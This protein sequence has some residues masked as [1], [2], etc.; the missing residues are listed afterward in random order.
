MQ[1]LSLQETCAYIDH[2]TNITG[3]PT[4]IFADDAKGKMYHSSEGIPRR[5]N[6]ICYRSIVNAVLNEIS[7]IDSKNLILNDFSD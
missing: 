7:I 1:G 2:Q 3:R 6:L 5:I 4:S